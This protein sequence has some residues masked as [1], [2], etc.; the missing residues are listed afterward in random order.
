MTEG[1][2]AEDEL[3]DI[4]F[5]VWP[6]EHGQRADLFLSR[7]IKRMSRSRAAELIRTG[8]VR[9]Q[10]GLIDRPSLKVHAGDRVLLRRK[11]L[12]EGPTEGIELPVVY[13]D[14]H[15]LAVSKPGDLVVHPTASAFHRTLIRILRTRRPTEFLELAHRLDKETSGLIILSRHPAVDI[16]LKDD[17]A[18]RRV[19]KAYLAVVQGVPADDEMVVDAPMRLS[20]TASS[21][22]RMEIGG[23]DALP[24][25]TRVRV[26]ARGQNA[27][28]VEARPETG[29]QHQI[30]LHLA[31]IGHP[32]I[33]D[34]LYL[35]GDEIFLRAINERLDEAT[36][37][38]LVGHPRQALHAWRA[39]LVHPVTRA[40]LRLEA[41]LAPDLAQLVQRLGLSPYST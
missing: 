39:E 6:E 13:E 23:V 38:D 19:K 30:R 18:E 32:I 21:G 25:I 3:V 26:L 7:R 33:G 27:A 15:V 34:K 28:V 2:D 1:E 40:P 24:S 41:P 16:R 10:S 31:H 8:K 9:R 35:G 22:V 29:R 4:P 5:S 37:I 14:E 11:R 36:L 12:E 20:P 17:F